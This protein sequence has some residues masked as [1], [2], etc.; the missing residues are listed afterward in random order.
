MADKKPGIDQRIRDAGGD[1]IRDKDGK[2]VV[3][4]DAEKKLL[5]NLKANQ[6]LDGAV[7]RII[8]EPMEKKDLLEQLSVL[9]KTY[10]DLSGFESMTRRGRL[11]I[12]SKARR[13]VNLFLQEAHRIT[14]AGT[15]K[16]FE[17]DF[18]KLNEALQKY[19]TVQKNIIIPDWRVYR[20]SLVDP[21]YSELDY[22]VNRSAFLL[23]RRVTL[24]DLYNKRHV[25]QELVDHVLK[26]MEK[27]DNY[28]MIDQLMERLNRE[29]PAGFIS[30][31]TVRVDKNGATVK[32]NRKIALDYYVKVWISDIESTVHAAT[33][34]SAFRQ[35]GLDLVEV[36]SSTEDDCPIC[37][38]INGKI[39]SL[40]GQDPDF[41]Q[42][43]F[44]LPLHP[45]CDHYLVPVLEG[46][47]QLEA[48]VKRK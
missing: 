34:E 48:D 12:L 14:D 5:R 28:A 39:F 31:P 26:N 38:R 44:T 30:A 27:T 35:A 29:F 24:F 37:A 10:E 43:D 46:G 20:Q 3:F 4:S 25:E 22:Y 7:N 18:V 8:H 17:D 36:K 11:D 15:R 16:L 23:E 21:K 9:L 40:S 33:T 19:T 42:M 2:R 1:I 13:A 6:D 32:Y 47:G 45:H 41:K